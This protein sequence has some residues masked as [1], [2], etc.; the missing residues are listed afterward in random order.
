MQSE[1][2]LAMSRVTLR[3]F[4]SLRSLMLAVLSPAVLWVSAATVGAGTTRPVIEK[5]DD[6][7]RHT[8]TVTGQATALY[9]SETR[10][11]LLTLAKAIQANIESGLAT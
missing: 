4:Y 8:Y 2:V 11:Q 5:Q 1:T 10:D 6:L 9:T 7:P 3:R